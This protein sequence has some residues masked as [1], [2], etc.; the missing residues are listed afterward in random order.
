M[1]LKPLKRQVVA[2]FGASSGIGREAALRFAARGARVVV[3]ARSEKGLDSLVSEIRQNGGDALAVRADASDFEQVRRVADTAVGRFGTLDTWVHAAAVGLY[4]PFEQTT[5]EEWRRVLDVNLNGQAYGAWAAL[6]HLRR[7]GR[8]ALIHISSVEALRALPL[9]SAYAASKHGVKAFTEALRVELQRDQAPI[10]VT[11]IMPASINTP[12]FNKA[13]TKIGYKPMGLPPIYTPDIVA[14]AILYAAENPVR[15]MICGGAG[16]M[17]K[18]GEQLAP[19]LMDKMLQ[20]AGFEWQR[21]SEP[22]SE[23]EP[24]NLFHPVAG[25]DRVRGDYTYQT[26]P[27]SIWTWWERHAAAGNLIAGA[28]LGALALTAARRRG[29]GEGGNRKSNGDPRAAI[30]SSAGG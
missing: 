27:K 13:R 15:E 18:T 14:K 9:H 19:H 20:Y 30:S 26:M 4:A 28:A 6:P 16:W 21:T 29:N 12:F 22:K 2:V 25:Y 23:N 17:I 3:S 8:G 11:N 10:S 1:K 24:D 5:P 7:E